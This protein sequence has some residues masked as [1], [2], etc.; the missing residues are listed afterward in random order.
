[1]ILNI[2]EEYKESGRTANVAR[3]EAKKMARGKGKFYREV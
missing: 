1:M 2:K 3:S